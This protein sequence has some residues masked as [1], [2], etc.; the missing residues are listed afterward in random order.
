MKNEYVIA[1]VVDKLEQFT[2]WK[3]NLSL[4]VD[5]FK[6]SAHAS[7]K[8]TNTSHEIEYVPII[9]EVPYRGFRLDGIV[10]ITPKTDSII[11]KLNTIL[12]SV[13]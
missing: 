9:S 5:T 4:Q 12:P 10:L 11:N 7:D 2:E 1:V 6:S 8:Y 13:H 3:R